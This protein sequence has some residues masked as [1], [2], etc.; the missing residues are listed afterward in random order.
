MLCQVTVTPRTSSILL[1]L[2]R[3]VE[4]KI[5]ILDESKNMLESRSDPWQ[6]S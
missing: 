4:S 5:R 3:V 1:T 6:W 2:A